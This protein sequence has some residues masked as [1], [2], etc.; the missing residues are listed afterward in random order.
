MEQHWAGSGLRPAAD[1][2]A[3]DGADPTQTGEMTD[4]AEAIVVPGISQTLDR[5]DE[6]RAPEPR[7]WPASQPATGEPR[8]DDVLRTLASLAD[9]PVSEH[10]PVFERIHGQLVEVLGELRSGPDTAGP[11]TLP[12]GGAGPG[13]RAG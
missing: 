9:L 1:D 12:P 5:S 6:V 7:S 13:R 2:G 8:V 3:S 10:P 4:D 11:G